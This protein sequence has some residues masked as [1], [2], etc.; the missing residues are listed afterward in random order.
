MQTA[1]GDARISGATQTIGASGVVTVQVNAGSGTA[2]IDATSGTQTIRGTSASTALAGQAASAGSVSGGVRVQVSGTGGTARIANS[3]GAQTIIGSFVDI[4]TAANGTA[5]V[6]AS[7]NQ[8]IHTTN[9]G[10][11]GGFG[12]LHVAANGGGSATL[13]SGGSQLLQIDYPELM[14][15]GRDG[16]ITVGSL[17]ATGTSVIRAVDQDIFARSID[18][19]GG[20]IAGANAKVDVSNVQNISLVSSGF[21]PT[22][23]LTVQGGAGGTALIDPVSQT[24]LSNGAISVLGG[25]GPGTSAGIFSTNDQIIVV[26]NPNSATSFLLQGGTGANASA[27]ITTSG[28]IQ[29]IRTPGGI[30]ITPGAGA[31]ADAFFSVGGGAGQLQFFCGATCTLTQLFID[32]PLNPPTEIGVFGVPVGVLANA[33]FIPV[34]GVGVI[35]SPFSLPFD[36]SILVLT[37]LRDSTIED[38]RLDV[39][40]GRRLPQCR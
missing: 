34:G 22:A 3:G 4:K 36:P 9:G 5:V 37:N 29:Q 30:T 2:S 11:S 26:T 8:S 17:G 1:A 24:I 39:L 31:N 40:F 12:S 18:V 10:A 15:S 38:E 19:V 7:G 14:Q 13:Q 16:R 25:T 27:Q 33:A 28:L 20:A 6:S 21:T 23:S 35:D 32:P